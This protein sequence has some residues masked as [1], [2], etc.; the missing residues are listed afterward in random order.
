ML[1]RRYRDPQYGPRKLA[2]HTN[3]L[4]LLEACCGIAEQGRS[5]VEALLRGAKFRSHGV[6]AVVL[7][8]RAAEQWEVADNNL[9]HGFQQ[10]LHGRLR[11]SVAQKTLVFSSATR[12]P[13]AANWG[14][15]ASRGAASCVAEPSAILISRPRQ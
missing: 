7:V 6:L 11:L 9:P 5:L 10:A 1:R 2:A 4:R 8:Q 14:A 13:N 3:L 12:R 15:R